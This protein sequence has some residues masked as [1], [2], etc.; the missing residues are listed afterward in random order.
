MPNEVMATP[1]S[2]HWAEGLI[3]KS[4]TPNTLPTYIPRFQFKYASH[5]CPASS[6]PILPFFFWFPMLGLTRN[7]IDDIEALISGSKYIKALIPAVVNIVYR[8]LLQ[9]DITARA[10][11]T[12][13]TS[14]EGPLDEFPSEDS[15]QIKHRKLFLKGYLNKLCS[16]PSKLEFWEYLDKV[17]WVVFWRWFHALFR[18]FPIHMILGWCTSVKG[19][20]TRFTSNTSI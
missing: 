15:P 5:Y 11:Q 16:D 7:W 17:G 1:Y 6:G 13:S 19:E 4:R 18:E 14:F 12:R 9:Y 8:K 20:N 2:K 3:H 10:F